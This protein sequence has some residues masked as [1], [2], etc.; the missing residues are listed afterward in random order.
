MSNKKSA[1][2]QAKGAKQ[3]VEQEQSNRSNRSGTSQ[4]IVKQQVEQKE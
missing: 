2:D 3:Q 4:T 1:I